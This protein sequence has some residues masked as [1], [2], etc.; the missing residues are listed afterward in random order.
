MTV[1]ELIVFLSYFDPNDIVMKGE[2]EVGH[3]YN[4]VEYYPI[5][6]DDIKIKKVN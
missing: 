5:S 3:G 4:D 2:K 6:R 1:K